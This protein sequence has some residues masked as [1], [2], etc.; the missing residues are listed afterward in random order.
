M[1][2]CDHKALSRHS[3]AGRSVRFPCPGYIQLLLRKIAGHG[4]TATT[5]R[6]LHPD[7]QPVS[8]Q[9]AGVALSAHLAASRSP[10]ALGLVV[11]PGIVT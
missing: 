7:P 4:L 5:Q 8:I 9:D 10:T 3:V 6:S 11:Q 1:T 2:A